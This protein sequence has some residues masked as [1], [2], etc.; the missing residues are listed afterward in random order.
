[1]SADLVIRPEQGF[2]A[3]V[4]ARSGEKVSRCYHCRKCTNG[5]PVSFAMDVMPNQVMRMIQLGLKEELLKSKTIWVCASC[6][7]CTTRCPNDIDIAHLMDTLRQMSQEAGVPP[8]DQSV[9]KFHKALLGS[10]RRHG[11]VF[12]PEMI[13]L[14]KLAARD[15]FSDMKLGWEMLKR[16]KLKFLPSRIKDKK[17]VRRMFDKQS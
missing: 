13:A 4:E 9:L 3:A 14:Y 11:R 8:A 15:F 16:G 1:M 7:T 5:C 17:E 12:E 2:L 6:Q 10:V